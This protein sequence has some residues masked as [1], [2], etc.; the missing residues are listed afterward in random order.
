MKL[1][2]FELDGHPKFDV[3]HLFVGMVPFMYDQARFAAENLAE[4]YRDFRVGATA[5]GVNTVTQST[6][7]R[8]NGNTKASTHVTTVCAEQKLLK[9]MQK[10]GIDKIVGIVVATSAEKHLIDKV[11]TVEAETLIPCV[12]CYDR[13]VASPLMHD[14]TL[15]IT[16]DLNTERYQVMM[17]ADLKAGYENPSSGI[18]Q[19]LP[20]HEGFDNWSVKQSTYDTLAI[21]EAV[22]PSEEQR[23][24]ALL[25]KMAIMS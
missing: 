5:F 18:I 4:S 17:F 16:A 3:Y 24:H 2:G 1:G 25:A 15:L 12:P 20:V 13:F 21:A 8:A 7:I 11:N 6:D 14:D 10:A 22:L 9:P 19:D 23:S